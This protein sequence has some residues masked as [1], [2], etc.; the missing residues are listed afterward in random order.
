MTVVEFAS[1]AVAAHVLIQPMVLITRVNVRV[2]TELVLAATVMAQALVSTYPVNKAVLPVNIV[3]V[4]V[5]VAVII[6]PGR[7]RQAVPGIISVMIV[8]LAYCANGAL[9]PDPS[10]TGASAESQL[11]NATGQ[12][13]SRLGTV[14]AVFTSRGPRIPA[15]IPG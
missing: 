1:P 11:Y 2:V 6:R 14:T 5:I 10:L 8:V 12:T 15:I 3:L 4:Q 13:E 7:N 9:L